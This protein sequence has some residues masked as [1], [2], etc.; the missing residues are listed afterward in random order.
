M[1]GL[2]LYEQKGN[3]ASAEQVRVLLTE[4]ADA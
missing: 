2:A 3:G 4:R 1:E